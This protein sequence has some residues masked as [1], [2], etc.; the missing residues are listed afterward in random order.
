ALTLNFDRFLEHQRF[1]GIDKLA[2]NNS[3]QDPSYLTEALCG[4]LFLA[5][6]VPTPRATHARVELNG[7]DLGF[8][9][10]KE[11][12]DRT[13]LRRHFQNVNGNLY[14]GGFLREITE[15][16]ERISGEGDVPN[17]ADL[18]ALAAAALEPNHSLRLER[19]EQVL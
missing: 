13:F 14:D 17:R 12:F 1:H 19:L 11:G 16:L 4:E 7:R 3:V 5:A 10:L 2:L 18:K 8:Y 9:V 6:G 15:P